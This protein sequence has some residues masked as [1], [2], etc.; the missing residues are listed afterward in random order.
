MAYL[1]IMIVIV[2]V[3]VI[4]SP[5]EPGVLLRIFTRGCV[6]FSRT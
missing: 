2:M 4:V 6:P 1:E 5:E 3:V